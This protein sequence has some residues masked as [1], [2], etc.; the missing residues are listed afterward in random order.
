MLVKQ[1]K[2]TLQYSLGMPFVSSQPMK[3][4]CTLAFVAAILFA[5]CNAN[6]GSQKKDS[7]EKEVSKEKKISKKKNSKKKNQI[8]VYIITIHNSLMYV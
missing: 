6:K 1:F 4:I 5:G 8:L 7:K 3:K 2:T